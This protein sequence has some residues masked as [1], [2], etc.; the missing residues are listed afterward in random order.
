[1]FGSKF[2]A[3]AVLGGLALF[4]AFTVNKAAEK[5]G[6]RVADLAWARVIGEKQK[7]DRDA[8]HRVDMKTVD[9]TAT[10]AE[11]ERQIRE[12]WLTM[13]RSAPTATKPK[14]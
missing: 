10:L 9:E 2:A 7:T 3:W 5:R 13:G 8:N 11:Q 14:E 6:V 12:R 4:V 1:M